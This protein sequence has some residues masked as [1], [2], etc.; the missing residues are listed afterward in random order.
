MKKAPHEDGAGKEYINALDKLYSTP[1]HH[2][3]K[4]LS[5][6]TPTTFGEQVSGPVHTPLDTP[7]PPKNNRGHAAAAQGITH[8]NCRHGDPRPLPSGVSWTPLAP[9]KK[10]VDYITLVDTHDGKPAGKIIDVD[11]ARKVSKKAH[12][13]PPGY[14]AWT[15]PIKDM[16]RDL[17][18]VLKKLKPHQA[19]ILSAVPGTEHGRRFQLVSG[20]LLCEKLGIDPGSQPLGLFTFPDEPGLEVCCRYSEN[21]AYSTVRV[22]DVDVA[23][24]MPERLRPTTFTA[25]RDLMV[26]LCPELER[27]AMVTV[28][29][30]SSRVMLPDGQPA[31]PSGGARF[32][33]DN[34]RQRCGCLEQHAADKRATRGPDL[35]EAC[36]LTHRR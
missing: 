26:S 12:G 21:F 16:A 4:N 23:A 11:A 36:S 31:L 8:F 7:M 10:G 34:R 35:D 24:D 28:P 3:C 20:Q 14:N 33:P 15:M 5:A 2:I 29:S 6:L 25:W 19:I 22:F 13:N 1:P 32:Y 9:D 17:P 30:S 18:G 27:A